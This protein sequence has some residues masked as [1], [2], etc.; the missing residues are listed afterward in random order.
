MC[1]FPA[2]TVLQYFFYNIGEFSHKTLSTVS[3]LVRCLRSKTSTLCLQICIAKRFFIPTYVFTVIHLYGPLLLPCWSIFEYILF[4]IFVTEIS[5]LK[6]KLILSHNSCPWAPRCLR[7]SPRIWRFVTAGHAKQPSR[8][9]VTFSIQINYYLFPIK[10]FLI[11]WSQYTRRFW[12]LGLNVNGLQ[13][14]VV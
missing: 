4:R 11:S 10:L 1:K 12:T 6:L 2:L 9:R 5:W 14:L 7:K 8:Q 13:L 3:A